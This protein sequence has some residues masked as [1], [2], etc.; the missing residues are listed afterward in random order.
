[1]LVRKKKGK[2]IDWNADTIEKGE[3]GGGEEEGGRGQKEVDPPSLSPWSA[4]SSPIKTR[5][6]MP[7][8]LPPPPPAYLSNEKKKRKWIDGPMDECMNV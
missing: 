7:P 2:G 8:N 1:M 5:L 4:D 6:A 3:K